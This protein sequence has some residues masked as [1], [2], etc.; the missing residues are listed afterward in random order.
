MRPPPTPSRIGD[1]YG[2]EWHLDRLAALRP[3]DWTIP[4]RR[5]RAP[6]AAPAGATRPR[7][8]RR[9]PSLAPSPRDL[10]DWLRAA[11]ADDEAAGTTK[12]ALWNLDRAVEITPDD[13]TLYATRAALVDL[14]GHPDRA[15]ADL[16]EAIRRGAEASLI[17]T[18]ADSQPGRVTGSM[19]QPF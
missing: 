5:G 14:A 7:G 17:A 10:A 3:N 8:L 6:G 4:A 2:A 18:A 16:D 12:A 1:A 11:A 19:R 13:W 9:R 15:T